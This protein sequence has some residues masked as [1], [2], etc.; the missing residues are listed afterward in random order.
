M[1]LTEEMKRHLPSLLWLFDDTE[2]PAGTRQTGRSTLLA[3]VFMTLAKQNPGK[4]IQ[5]IDHTRTK[6]GANYVLRRIKQ[7]AAS[8]PYSNAANEWM[9]LYISETGG[10]IVYED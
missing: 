5:V 8:D 9:M 6:A 3:H 1:K 2:G 7:L 4:L 10:Y